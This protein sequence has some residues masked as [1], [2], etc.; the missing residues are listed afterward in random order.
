MMLVKS[1]PGSGKGKIITWMLRSGTVVWT[2]FTIEMST[3][4]TKNIVHTLNM[5]H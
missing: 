4:V 1:W 3:Q 2:S 5:I